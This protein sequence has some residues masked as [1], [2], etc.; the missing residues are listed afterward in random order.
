MALVNLDGVPLTQVGF[1]IHSGAFHTGGWTTI[2]TIDATN[3]A[4]IFIGQIWTTDGGSHIIDTSGSSALGWRTNNVALSNA[5]TI[6]KVGLATVDAG[7]IPPAR[8]T[9][10]GNVITFQVSRSL[11]K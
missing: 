1:P 10:V 9:N 11:Y 6:V 5:G 3:E 4:V 2:D 8:A 7:S